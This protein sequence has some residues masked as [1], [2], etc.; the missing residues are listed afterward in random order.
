MKINLREI[1]AEGRTYDFDR[2]TG[3]LNE[4][5]EDL[6]GK[7]PY[8]VSLFIKPM[9]NVFEMTG[10]LRASLPEVCSKCGWDLEL[11]ISRKFHEFLMEEQ[12]SPRNAQSVHGNHSVDF[13]TEG[14]SVTSTQNDV[15]D[16]AAYV[17][18]AVGLAT[19]FYPWCED[20]QCVHLLEVE[21]KRQ[22]LEQ[23]YAT[24]ETR[25]GHPAFSVLKT[26]KI[27]S[28]E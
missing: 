12:D 5:L 4:A 3:E 27:K 10:S 1:P 11:K 8:N 2:E 18:E 20:S 17:H 22:E 13:L 15:F 16:S 14:P 24:T 25:A 21:A 6:L 19:P 9:G 23:S 28:Q 26:V 7:R